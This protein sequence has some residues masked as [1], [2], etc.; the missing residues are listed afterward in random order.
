MSLEKNS[1]AQTP[2][3]LFKNNKIILLVLL[4]IILFLICFF[5]NIE[6]ISL[7]LNPNEINFNH[8]F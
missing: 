3:K 7:L 6:I 5:Y 4:N 8:S 1:I 2:E